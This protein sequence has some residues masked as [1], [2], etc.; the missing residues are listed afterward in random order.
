M[1]RKHWKCT[2]LSYWDHDHESVITKINIIINYK[3]WVSTRYLKT[4]SRKIIFLINLLKLLTVLGGC[5]CRCNYNKNVSLS[6]ILK[7]PRHF[8]IYSRLIA[9][10]IFI[11]LSSY[12]WL[13]LFSYLCNFYY[14]YYLKGNNCLYIY[15]FGV[16]SYFTLVFLFVIDYGDFKSACK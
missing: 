15:Y 2:L 16:C 10:R 3:V 4:S 11:F 5:W 6:N 13:W 1:L 12:R 9:L 14:Y 8:L 7:Y